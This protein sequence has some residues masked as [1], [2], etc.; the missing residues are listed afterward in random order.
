[1][2]QNGPVSVHVTRLMLSMLILL[3]MNAKYVLCHV[4]H[5][6]ITQLARLVKQIT[7]NL[8]VHL[9]LPV[10]CN[11]LRHTIKT[12]P[13]KHVSFATNLLLQAIASNAKAQLYFAH[14]A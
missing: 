5:A 1:M 8:P 2:E 9:M 12:I 11:A 7:T 4:Q 6:L 10:F 14:H 13:P 3:R